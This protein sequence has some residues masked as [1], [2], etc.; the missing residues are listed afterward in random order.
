MPADKPVAFQLRC[1]FEQVVAFEDDV[2]SV[3]CPKCPD[4]SQQPLLPLE[5]VIVDKE[6]HLIETLV[7][8]YVIRADPE[9][10]VE[11]PVIRLFVKCIQQE[12]SDSA[13]G[14]R[15]HRRPDGPVV[16]LRVEPPVEIK[17]HRPVVLWEFLQAFVVIADPPGESLGDKGL[18]EH[19]TAKTV[20]HLIEHIP[21]FFVLIW[22]WK[23]LSAAQAVGV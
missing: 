21:G 22:P 11:Q 8:L 9:P 7:Q 15:F 12:G 10:S 16:M 14:I 2:V 18:A 4:G 20:Y 3:L 13:C 6:A 1:P 5:R 23:D 17:D 19:V